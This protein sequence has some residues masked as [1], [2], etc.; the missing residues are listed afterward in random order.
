MR[1]P[2]HVWTDPAFADEPLDRLL[3]DYLEHLKGRSNPVST[4]TVIKYHK[5]LLSLFRSLEA[6]GDP[7]VAG[8][9]T[10]HAVNR[11]VNEQRQAGRS[12]DGTASR[13]VAIKVFTNKYLYKEIELTTV[14][15]LRKVQ[16]IAPPEKPAP[17]LDEAELERI[18]ACLDRDTFEDV[19]DR[20]ITAF[21]ASTG[22]RFREVLELP[23]ESL[24]RLNGDVTGIRAKGNR[25]RQARISARALK[26]VR[27]YLKVRPRDCPSERLWVSEEGHPLSYWGGQSIFRRLKQRSGISRVRSHLFRHG[28]A[29]AALSKGADPSTVQEML[30]HATNVMTRRYLGQVRQSVAARQMPQFSPV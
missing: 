1:H 26:Y 9:L 17:V 2:P 22:L 14:D 12:E 29:Q 28:F 7:L 3:R 24:D 8:S 16:R 21:Y 6:S 30:G 13:L 27:A 10:P 11:W 23:L 15:L 25:E 19:R 4:D 20:A 5:S 18:L